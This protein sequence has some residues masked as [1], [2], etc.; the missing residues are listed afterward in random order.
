[1]DPNISKATTGKERVDTACAES[2]ST[3]RGPNRTRFLAVQAAIRA[4]MQCDKKSLLSSA[5][6]SKQ[7]NLM[8]VGGHSDNAV[9]LCGEDNADAKRQCLGD[10]ADAKRQ[11]LGVKSPS[12]T[13]YGSRVTMSERMINTKRIYDMAPV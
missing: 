5:D 7:R 6:A 13:R 11:C 8:V 10:N 2:Q 12:E 1:M 9:D 4:K 3:S